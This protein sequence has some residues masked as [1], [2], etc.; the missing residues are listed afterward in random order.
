MYK[1]HEICFYASES[2]G[3]RAAKEMI[4]KKD[5]INHDLFMIHH[6]IVGYRPV[7]T[8]KLK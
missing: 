6:E 3:N 2:L 7:F 4:K 1:A 5:K 8:L